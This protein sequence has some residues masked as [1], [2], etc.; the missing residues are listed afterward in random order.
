MWN[1]SKKKRGHVSFGGTLD[2]DEILL[3]SSNLPSFDRDQ[4]EGRVE[5]SIKGYIPLFVG[6]FVF[7]IF[8][9][10]LTQIWMLQVARGEELSELSSKNRLNHVVIFA[11]RGVVYDRRGEELVWNEPS[12]VVEDG[13]NPKETTYLTYARRKYTERI[14]FAHVLGFIGYPEKDS[15]GNWWRTEYVGKSGVENSLDEK[16][17]GENGVRIVEVNALGKVQSENSIREP[18]DGESVSLSID[19][20]LQEKLFETIRDGARRSN[21]VAGAGVIMDVETG[22]IIAM[23]SFPEFDSGILT[24]GTDREEIATYATDSRQ[25]FL[26]RAV[27]GE[28]TPGSIVK[29]FMASAALQEKIISPTKR[30]L[31]TGELRIPNPYFPG[32]YSIF[33]DWKVH[34]WVDMK[35][36]ISVSSNVY[37]YTVG[38]G[39]GDQ[40]GLGIER[41]AKYANM[42]GFGRPTGID[43]GTE[44]VGVVPTP[45]WKEEVFGEDNPW[46]IGNTYHTSIGQFGFL[47]TPIQVA[48]YISSIANGGHLLTPSINKG[49]KTSIREVAVDDENLSIVRSGMKRGV[50][51]GTVVSLNVWGI[52]IA[53]KTG[54][55]QLGS[56]NEYM[57][58]WAVGFWPA[59][60][61]KFAFAT[62]LEKAPANTLVGA[63][64]AMRGFFEWLVENEKEYVKGEYPSN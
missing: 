48:R 53:G 18:E 4:F 36:A 3:D 45:K 57:N 19:A 16:L 59:D 33:R 23:T 5:R 56:K 35:Q 41:I 24:E 10:F 46:R 28:Y 43:I 64:P 22:E 39:F 6:L 20:L 13:E 54:T 58:S 27:A 50:Q 8:S 11:D 49:A 55:A 12:L 17:K 63:A 26:N 38:G 2:P 15:R 51:S 42:F 29:P 7:I 37:F 60:D 21:F 62:V 14:G 31:S 32:Q 34:G 44:S 47:V 9:G 1:F 30:I 40:E 61:P 25:P 52:S